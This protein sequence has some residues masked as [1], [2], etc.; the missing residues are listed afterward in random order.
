[1]KNSISRFRR[2]LSKPVPADWHISNF[3]V[4]LRFLD[5]Y[6]VLTPTW[7]D[8][9]HYYIV[10]LSADKVHFGSLR[11]LRTYRACDYISR[12]NSYGWL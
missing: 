7:S 9:D 12:Y 3:R 2:S 10:R 8:R 11:W 1:M 5:V 6:L 4:R